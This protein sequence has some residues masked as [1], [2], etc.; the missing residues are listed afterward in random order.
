ML[1]IPNVKSK[2]SE[3]IAAV[4]LSPAATALQLLLPNAVVVDLKERSSPPTKTGLDL[5]KVDPSPTS[6]YVFLP[7]PNN[8]AP[9]RIPAAVLVANLIAVQ[10][11][12]PT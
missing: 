7:Q 6:P 2:P 10:E 9:F 4:T 1:L 3:R 8:R 5:C 12:V 11:D